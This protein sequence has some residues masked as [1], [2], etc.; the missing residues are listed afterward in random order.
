ML[1]SSVRQ[2]SKTDFVLAEVEDLGTESLRNDTAEHSRG[3]GCLASD[4][5][6]KT[7]LDV[8]RYST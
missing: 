6:A 2:S 5:L 4:M 1:L 7:V 8:L 3:S